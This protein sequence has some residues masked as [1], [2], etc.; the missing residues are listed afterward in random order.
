MNEKT[1]ERVITTL[2]KELPGI[3]FLISDSLVDDGILDSLTIVTMI[4]AL[5][6]EFGIMFDLDEL[7][8]ENLNSIEAITN[9]IEKLQRAE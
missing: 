8:P 5:S 4:S 3:D 7:T 9:T 2:E 1:K 6:M